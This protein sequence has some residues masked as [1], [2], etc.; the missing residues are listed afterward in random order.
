MYFY[1]HDFVSY[2]SIKVTRS[3]DQIVQYTLHF[4]NQICDGRLLGRSRTQI[5]VA[6]KQ[7][8]DEIYRL[9]LSIKIYKHGK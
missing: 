7:C 9:K 2:T 8:L 6:L 3:H 1:L 5:I 4:G